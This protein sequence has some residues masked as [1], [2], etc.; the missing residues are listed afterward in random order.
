MPAGTSAQAQ[1][2]QNPNRTHSIDSKWV[3]AREMGRC[4][5]FEDPPA[6]FRLQLHFRR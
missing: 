1:I 3:A 5:W 4:S 2:P 6:A